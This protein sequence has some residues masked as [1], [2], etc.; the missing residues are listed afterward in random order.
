MFSF[1][2]TLI[3]FELNH[4]A[5]RLCN[6]YPCY[7]ILLNRLVVYLLPT[8]MSSKIGNQT[9]DLFYLLKENCKSILF[10]SLITGRNFDNLSYLPNS[11]LSQRWRFRKILSK[12]LQCTESNF[13][14]TK[15]SGVIFQYIFGY[16]SL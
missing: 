8:A 7:I 5:I 6:K 4:I 12:V 11:L 10:D 15:V 2:C 16:G 13:A 9:M 14:Y 3:W 1:V